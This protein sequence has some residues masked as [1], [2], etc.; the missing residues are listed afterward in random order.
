MKGAPADLMM[1]KEDSSSNE[2]L[3]ELKEQS[4]PMKMNAASRAAPMKMQAASAAPMRNISAEPRPSFDTVIQGQST[5][6]S[7]D[8]SKA[9]ILARCITGNTIEDAGVRQALSQVTLSSGANS[10]LVYL[11]LL[12]LFILQE[13]FDDYEDEWELIARKAKTFLQSAGV[14]KPDTFVRQFTL[15]PVV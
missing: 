15:T 9:S 6:G 10:E 4:A 14:Q 8:S 7:W 3:E 12:A 5:N 13:C 1:C 2:S 11:T